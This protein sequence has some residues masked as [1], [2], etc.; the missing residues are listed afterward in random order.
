MNK[1]PNPDII[2]FEGPVGHEKAIHKS[3]FHITRKLKL[4]T[5]KDN[6][7]AWVRVGEGRY[8]RIKKEIK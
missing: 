6:G 7:Y 4:R 1:I 2:G 3:H 8:K 5:T